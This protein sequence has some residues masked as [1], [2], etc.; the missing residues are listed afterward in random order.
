MDEHLYL[1]GMQSHSS[2]TG[3]EMIS[4]QTQTSKH[5]KESLEGSSD[6]LRWEA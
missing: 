6:I 5:V 4:F 1:N 2:C 3:A